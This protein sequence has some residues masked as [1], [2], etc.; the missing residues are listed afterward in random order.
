MSDLEARE[1][2]LLDELAKAIDS[3]DA[4]DARRALSEFYQKH[5][6]AKRT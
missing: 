5:L 6:G 2:K 4:T 3:G 1:R